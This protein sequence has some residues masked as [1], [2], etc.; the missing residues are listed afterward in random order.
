MI[1]TELARLKS[2]LYDVLGFLETSL[3]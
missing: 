1:T 3:S 2:I